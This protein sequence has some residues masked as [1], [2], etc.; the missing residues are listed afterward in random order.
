MAPAEIYGAASGPEGGISEKSHDA[1][2]TIV[3]A[4]DAPIPA[5]ESVVDLLSEEARP[6]DPV[7]A[8]RVLRKIDRFLLPVLVVGYGLTYWDK[9]ILGSAALFGMTTDLE[10]SV[11][12]PVTG[13][14]DTSRLSWATSLFYFGQ[15]AG[16]L[17]MSY[18]V[19]H[20]PTRYVL[21]P[22]IMVWAV[23]C[24]ATA[25][26]TTWQ[27]LYV[28]RFFLGFFESIIPTSFLLIVGSFY[29]QAEQTLRQCWWWTAS[30]WFILIGGG[31]NYGFA[32]I[33]TGGLHSW[34]Y[35]YI[36]AGALTFLF[37]LLGFF[38]P[39]SP[40]DAW[41]LTPEERVVAV[42]RLRAGQTGVR[43]PEIK[44]SQ[45]REA[46]LDVKVW[47]IALIMASGYTVNGAVTGF[48]P[49]IVSTFGFSTL[50]SILLQFPLGIISACS[51]LLAGWIGSRVPNV[52]LIIVVIACL[53]TMAA[54]IIIWKSHWSSHAAAPVIGY[55]LMGCFSPVVSMALVLASTNVAGGTKKSFMTGVLFVAYCVGNIVGPQMIRSQ[56][57]KQ[58]YPALWGGL[59]GCY[60]ITILS[61]A[62]LYFVLHRENK[63]R[64]A[65]DM[66]EAERSKLS[67]KDLTDKQNK[68]FRYAL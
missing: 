7:A 44:V 58:H 21:G 46:I 54:F 33:K 2:P 55:S 61:A 47:L 15:L 62:A 16:S 10:L 45:I 5:A 6:V 4:T 65:L 26:V 20:L 48:G 32:Q 34:Q 67:F 40:V 51:M 19:Q 43:N 11:I 3:T 63:K 66:D 13:A 27:G 1:V 39:S 60:S 28:Q 29:T 14:K 57:V 52:R 24:A 36:F 49:L 50:D 30:G 37:G 68:Y 25:G 59:L 35:I 18:L 22:G 8:K 17:P 12:D 53:P 42:E 64:E 41:I 38:I 31:L 9:A 23:V 56:T